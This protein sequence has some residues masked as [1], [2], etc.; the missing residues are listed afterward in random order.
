MKTF[1]SDIIPKIQ[2]FSEKLDN[3][4]LLL[5]QRWV[6]VGD[7]DNNKIIYIFRQN[8]ELLISLNGKVDKAK[9]EYLDKSSI[10]VD[11]IK[12]SYIY[13]HGFLDE[14]I[15]ALKIDSHNDFFFLVNESILQHELNTTEEVLEFIK[16]K[17][18][19]LPYFENSQNQ[20]TF[21]I[22]DKSSLKKIAPYNISL[23]E[24]R[25]GFGVGEMKIFEIKFNNGLKG[26]YIQ[27]LKDSTYSYDYEKFFLTE[28]EC[29]IKIFE[30]KNKK[31]DL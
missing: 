27:R 21:D 17:Y 24:E 7:N 29:I 4:T 5:N 19:D 13:K 20:L 1:I 26:T 22:T 6:I 14:K 2:K 8:N 3:T 12:G 25:W 18:L 23:I 11:T 31:T 9:W 16:S 28:Q 30:L 10:L 15:L